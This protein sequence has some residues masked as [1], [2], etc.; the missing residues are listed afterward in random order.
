MVAKGKAL[1]PASG[2][3]GRVG[4]FVRGFALRVRAGAMRH[5][6]RAMEEARAALMQQ[7]TEC[8]LYQRSPSG[9]P[10][11]PRITVYGDFRDGNPLLF[12]L[13]SFFTWRI[14]ESGSGFSIEMGNKKYY[15]FFHRKPYKGRPARDF[16]PDAG[17]ATPPQLRHQMQLVGARLAKRIAGLLGGR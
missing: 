3:F 2:D 13:L 6:R 15:A 4:A 9:V 14:V 5:E 8:F 16:A 11:P 1:M 12:D 7:V 10:W 17:S